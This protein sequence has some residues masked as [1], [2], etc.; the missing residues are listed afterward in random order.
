MEGLSE[1]KR[2]VYAHPQQG[3]EAYVI[4]EVYAMDV[5]VY[6]LSRHL[7]GR[8]DAPQVSE[9]F[10]PPPVLAHEQRASWDRSVTRCRALC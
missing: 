6:E 9:I 1:E 10:L 2:S 5:R 4:G 8:H 7:A 3:A